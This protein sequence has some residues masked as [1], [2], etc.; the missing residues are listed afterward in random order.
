MKIIYAFA[1]SF[2]HTHKPSGI[3][4]FNHAVVPTDIISVQKQLYTE[5][6]TGSQET[7]LRKCRKVKQGFVYK[8]RVVIIFVHNDGF[9]V[10][11]KYWNARGAACDN[12]IRVDPH[13]HQQ[14]GIQPA[15][16]CVLALL[17]DRANAVY[18][19]TLPHA[20]RMDVVCIL[21]LRG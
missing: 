20:V 19:Y 5:K 9:G 6:L 15:H 14:H 16:H 1:A 17:R 12:K 4:I 11:E 18:V 21:P 7:T 2:R 3:E 8:I 10:T 13:P